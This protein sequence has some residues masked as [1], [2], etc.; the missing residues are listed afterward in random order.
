MYW[1]RTPEASELDVLKVDPQ[2]RVMAFWYTTVLPAI[3]HL[4]Q[5][6]GLKRFFV[7]EATCLLAEGVTYDMI[8]EETK[9]FPAGLFG[10]GNYVKSREQYVS[11]HGTKGLA[12]SSQWCR[13]WSS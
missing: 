7:L 12:V 2:A 13:E 11:W 1:I 6:F 4:H 3:E 9:A 5:S 10:Y 8:H